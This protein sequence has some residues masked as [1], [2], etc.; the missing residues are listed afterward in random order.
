MIGYQIEWW[1]GHGDEPPCVVARRA[2]D[3]LRMSP[4]DA[5]AFAAALIAAANA[6]EDKT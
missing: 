5:R 6:S 1:R 4:S 2:R 3:D